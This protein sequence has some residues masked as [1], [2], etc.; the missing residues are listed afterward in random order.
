MNNFFQR[1]NMELIRAGV[2]GSAAGMLEQ[3]L[4]DHYLT[5]KAALLQSGKED[6]EADRLALTKLGDPVQLAQKAR[7]ELDRRDGNPK[8]QF[9]LRFVPLCLGPLSWCT[10]MGILFLFINT[11][12]KHPAQ[13]LHSLD[14]HHLLPNLATANLLCAL[15]LFYF[16]GPWLAAYLWILR[17]SYYPVHSWRYLLI[18]SG[19]LTL[20]YYICASCILPTNDGLWLY[21]DPKWTNVLLL[22]L[23][24]L[25]LIT[26]WRVRARK[27]AL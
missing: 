1:L 12:P 18:L 11:F 2:W 10:V 9:L 27:M 17:A 16:L 6:N 4:R 24:L 8:T 14:P 3:E 22:F 15:V 13:A 26:P 7:L 20:S 19:Y 21:L 5:E 23:C 25:L